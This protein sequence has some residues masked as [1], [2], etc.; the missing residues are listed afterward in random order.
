MTSGTIN[1]STKTYSWTVNLFW[2]LVP[3]TIACGIW[4]LGAWDHVTHVASIILTLIYC[5]TTSFRIMDARATVNYWTK[6][7]LWSFTQG[8][9][10]GGA[11]IFA[12]PSG[13]VGYVYLMLV[14][15]NFC[16]LILEW[17]RQ[18]KVN[19]TQ[20][21]PAFVVSEGIEGRWNYH[22]SRSDVKAVSLCGKTTM[23]TNIPLT[24]WNK[25]PKD[26]HLP[27]TWCNKC[28]EMIS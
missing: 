16:L 22:I 9:V 11:M 12:W 8:G 13:L 26:Y 19:K 23:L 21:K 24:A 17:Q 6:K 5:I 25:T 20:T 28:E 7:T 3:L 15:I 27:E 10:W 2:I 14:F 1:D 4:D 18:R